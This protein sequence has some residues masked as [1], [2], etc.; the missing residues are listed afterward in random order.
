MKW[1]EVRA[2]L[3]AIAI[4]F[5]L[6]DGCPLP[7]RAD[8]PPWERGFVEPIRAVRDTVATP[9][10]WVTPVLRVSQRWALYQ[11]PGGTR[12]RLWVEGRTSDGQWKILYRAGDGEHTED[13]DVIESGLVWNAYDPADRPPGQYRDFCVWLTQRAFVRHPDLVAVRV[14]QEQIELGHGEFVPTGKFAFEFARG[15]R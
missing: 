12:Y 13:A 3:V 7:P 10:S 9:M 1:R 5:G 14:R 4:A 6:I 15:K 11:R 2:G 8:T